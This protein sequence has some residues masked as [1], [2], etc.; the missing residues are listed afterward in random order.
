MIH[1]YQDRNESAFMNE[2]FSELATFLNGYDNGGFDRLYL[3][4]TD[5]INLTDWLGNA[6]DNSAH[7]GASFLF[8][9]Y[10]LDRF[11]DDTT[12]ALIHHQQNGL[13]GIDT[14]LAERNVT[15]PLTKKA[16]TADDFFQDWTI[17]NFVQD[18]SV[19]DG[20]YVYHNYPNAPSA[21]LTETVSTCPADTATRTV[22]QYGVDYIRVSCAGSHTLHFEGTTSTRL[23]PSDPH[24][25]KY[26]FWS[27]LGDKSDMTL[28]HEFDLS[29]VSKSAKIDFQLLDLV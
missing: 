22:N 2:G 11:G 16:I 23:V 15:D 20:R 17:A 14:V 21:A 5:S 24:S 26:A 6:G 4:N 9:T 12:K 3:S 19:G 7:Y 1:W 10:F 18:G 27:N 25:G 28:T 29:Q 8:V 13:D